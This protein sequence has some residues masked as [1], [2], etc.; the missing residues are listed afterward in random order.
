VLDGGDT[1]FKTAAPVAPADPARQKNRAELVARALVHTGVDAVN[2]GRKDLAAG[3]DFLADLG[4]S[5][6]LPWVASNL[7]RLDGSYPFPRWKVVRWGGAQVAVV[8]VLPP[9]P[10]RD[11]ALGIEV[12]EPA[13]A[14]GEVVPALPPVD[15]V[16]CLSNLGFDQERLL[17]RAVPGIPLIVG[18]GIVRYLPSPAVE[19]DS[20]ILYA[21]DRGRFLGVLDL[22]AA[23]LVSFDAHAAAYSHRLQPLDGQ[24]GEEAAVA[25]WVAE[26]KRLESRTARQSRRLERPPVPPPAARTGP[27]QTGT[28]ACRECHLGEYSAWWTTGHARS[29]ESLKGVASTGPCL[30]CHA[31]RIWRGAGT[32][33]EPVVGC[34]SCHGPGGNHRARGNIA[35]SPAVTVCTVCHR[36]YHPGEDFDYRAF[37]D[38]I[39][40][41]RN[42]PRRPPPR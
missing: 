30:E 1:L 38:R 18:G 32:S 27:V 12:A 8:G 25:E 10:T 26:Q 42:E 19:G 41:D 14:L 5:P 23:T 9:E 20:L 39:R 34:E 13:A 40:C 31:A 22:P 37:Y 7:R 36:G 17:A 11:A 15:A 4:R 33:I 29:Y 24:V 21:A 6:G 2:V 28:A 3:L 35:R 16:V